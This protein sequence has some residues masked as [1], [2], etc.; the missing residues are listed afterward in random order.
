MFVSIGSAFL[1]YAWS[2]RDYGEGAI[3]KFILG[4]IV[5]FGSE[6]V[7]VVLA[8]KGFRV[9]K[10]ITIV[11]ISIHFLMIAGP[12]IFL[13]VTQPRFMKNILELLWSLV[14]QHQ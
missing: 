13:C 14:Y 6:F 3:G 9:R 11:V 5:Y 12:L 4:L 2:M 8:A 10:N 1:F 7:A